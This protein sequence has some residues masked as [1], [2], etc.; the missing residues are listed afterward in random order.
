MLGKLVKYEL[1]ATS[2]WF[3]PIYMLVLLLAPLERITI[4][5]SQSDIGRQLDEPFNNIA[6]VAFVMLTLA[7]GLSLL[8]AVLSSV[9]LVIYR[10]YKNMVTNEGYLMHTLPVKTSALIWSKAIAALIWFFTS[11]IVVCIAAFVL[12]IGSE[13]WTEALHA[14]SFS[15]TFGEFFDIYG[16]NPDFWLLTV[17]VIYAILIAGLYSI[18]MFYAAISI[19]QLFRKHKVAGAFLAYFV[20]DF[21]VNFISTITAIPTFNSL[22]F[23][24]SSDIMHML[25]TGYMPLAL[26]GTTAVAAG[27]YFI[28]W[29]IFKNRL[30][31]E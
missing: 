31:L 24:G 15:Q 20:L 13:A 2:R 12:I 11:I 7:Y 1:K 17:E 14:F 23:P 6:A 4:A 9:L 8:A 28:T 26:L 25:A 18:F 3:L 16:N 27:F 29:Y 10:F 21:I 5:L 19:G 22:D 30:N